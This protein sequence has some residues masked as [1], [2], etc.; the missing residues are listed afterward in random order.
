MYS[1]VSDDYEK[2]NIRQA[3]KAYERY[4][5]LKFREARRNDRNSIYFFNGDGCFSSLGMQNNQMQG[6]SLGQ[7]CRSV[8]HNFTIHVV[9]NSLPFSLKPRIVMYIISRATLI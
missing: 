2:N 9:S 3:I 6:V 5:C 1:F 4:T 7:G 8:G